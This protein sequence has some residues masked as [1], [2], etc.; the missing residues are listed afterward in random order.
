MRTFA[1]DI[2]T[3]AT[4]W[5]LFDGEDLVKYGVIKPD[6]EFSQTERY[7][8]VTQSVVTLLKIFK[9][10]D[11]AIE[12]T[13]YSKDP[14]VLKKLNRIAGQIMYAWYAITRKEP[15]FYMASQA[16]GAIDVS[17]KATKKEVTDAV[18]IHF[19][20]RGKVKDDNIAD[21]IV[22]GACHTKE[23]LSPESYDESQAVKVTPKKPKSRKHS[24]VGTRGNRRGT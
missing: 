23:I 19:K 4:G 1:L 2:S 21:A 7:F 10:T 9:P 5:A 15:F 3:V 14:T 18:N 6:P 24:D 12:D 17:G 11:L 22:I 13:F 20:L 16:R 8:F